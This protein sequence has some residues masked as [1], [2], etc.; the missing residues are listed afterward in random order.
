MDDSLLWGRSLSVGEGLS[1]EV[2]ESR[3]PST[4]ARLCC[5]PCADSIHVRGERLKAGEGGTPRPP[6]WT[7]GPHPRHPLGPDRQWARGQRAVHVAPR[8]GGVRGRAAEASRRGPCLSH[9]ETHP[10]GVWPLFVAVGYALWLSKNSLKNNH[11]LSA[12]RRGRRR[13]EAHS[14]THAPPLPSA[15]QAQ[16]LRGRGAGRGSDPPP[17]A[18][19]CPALRPPRTGP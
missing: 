19:R 17:A 6:E 13:R 14:H 12:E 2:G 3:A 7:A 8:E 10:V 5:A 16:L 4:P 1:W 15:L 11:F 18:S 9:Q